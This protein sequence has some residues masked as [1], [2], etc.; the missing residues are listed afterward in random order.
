MSCVNEQS[1]ILDR[2]RK[3]TK[4]MDHQ[5]KR[6]KCDISCIET[7]NWLTDLHISSAC[8]LLQGQFP[9]LAGFQDSIKSQNCSFQRIDNP[10]VQIIHTDG[11]HCITLSGIHASLVKV[12]DS[13][14][15]SISND[16]KKQIAS[17]MVADKKHIDVHIENTQY[18]Q[19]SSDCGLYAIAF[20]T[21]ICFGN[22]PASY[23]FV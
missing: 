7:W 20:I 12:Y 18:Q 23:R 21:E 19:G 17:L 3:L 10:Y 5:L 13:I 9:T 16:T 15:T 1:D 6:R 8:E 2:K 22:K 14:K 11:N 4:N